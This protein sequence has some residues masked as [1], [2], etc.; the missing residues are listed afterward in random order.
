MPTQRETIT[1]CSVCEST[2]TTAYVQTNAMMHPINTEV[3]NFRY[4]QSC[5][6]VFL[7]NPVT[8]EALS[9][10]YT[11][12]YLPYKGSIAWGK[13]AFFV[14]WDE[15]KL[16]EKRKKITLSCLSKH[17]SAQ[18]LDVGCGK[19]DFLATLSKVP[20]IFCTGVDFVSANW[21]DQSYKDITLVACDWKLFQFDMKFNV[22]T[23]WHYLE[24]DYDL[25][26]TVNTFYE[27]LEH[28]GHVIIEVPMYEGVLQKIQRKH[29]QGWHSPRHINLFSRKSWPL[30]FPP[31]K[32]K[33]VQHKSYGTL[34][35][36]TLWWLGR[37]QKR[38]TNWS[39]SME[40][41]FF[42]LLAWKIVLTPIF[43]LEKIF[44]FGVQ[45]I[46]VQKK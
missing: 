30:V 29:W 16:N 44:P 21:E 34:S 26:S 11:Q 27:L 9:N 22:I 43:L 28:Q 13:Y 42:S 12:H 24:H 36:F 31:E 8:S 33:V 14:E 25:K 45:T 18:V 32:W 46:I 38:V 1:S 23:A 41:Y 15:R 40:P 17:S 2:Q 3:Y 19:P 20:S 10:Y 4:C 6:S 37:R 39:G 35:A 5:Q 7:S